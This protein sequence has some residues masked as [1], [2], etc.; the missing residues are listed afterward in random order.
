MTNSSFTSI[1]Q[2]TDKE[3]ENY[4]N[5]SKHSIG[6]PLFPNL[7]KYSNAKRME[8]AIWYLKGWRRHKSQGRRKQDKIETS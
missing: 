4:W 7:Y 5:R 3:R 2:L 6:L 8:L 1:W